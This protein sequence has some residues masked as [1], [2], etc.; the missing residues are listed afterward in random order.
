M[1]FEKKKILAEE[2]YLFDS[3]LMCYVNREEGKIFSK[4]WVEQKNLRTLQ[5]A[6]LMPHRATAWKIFLSYD[7]HDEKMRTSLFEKYGNTP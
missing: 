2:G 7:Q 4:E 1:N 5:I 3:E 6:T